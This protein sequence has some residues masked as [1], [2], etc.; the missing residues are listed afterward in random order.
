M[1]QPSRRKVA[2]GIA[3]SIPAITVGAAAPAVAASQVSPSINRSFYITRSRSGCSSGSRLTVDSKNDGTSYY[4]I[5]NVSPTSSVTAV[6][7]SV[8]VNLSGLSFTE[9]TGNWS[10]VQQDSQTYSYNGVTYYRYFAKLQVAIP[11][12]V[13]GTITVPSLSWVSNCTASLSNP[14]SVNGRG[15]VTINGQDIEQVGPFRTL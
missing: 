5:V 3:W 10:A 13:N 7:A 14:V 8:L 12:P 2:A 4:Q 6:Y 11:A 1:N 15:M 9:T